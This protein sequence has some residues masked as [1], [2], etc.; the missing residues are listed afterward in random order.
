MLPW[1]VIVCCVTDAA[2][3][4]LLFYVCLSSLVQHP[5]CHPSLSLSPSCW[6]E[7]SVMVTALP[8]LV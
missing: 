3:Y 2:Y 7:K 4:L 8:V 6:T 1:K 5:L